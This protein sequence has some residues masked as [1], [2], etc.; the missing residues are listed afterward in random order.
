MSI[1]DR[2]EKKLTKELTPTHLKIIDESALHAGHVGARPEGETHF[3]IKISS[4]EFYG[5]TRLEK[6]R[7]IYSI[8]KEELDGPVHAL[9]IE[10]E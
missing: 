9:S 4:L 3:R 5:K 1:A 7:R 6:Q 2:I 10:A 8:L